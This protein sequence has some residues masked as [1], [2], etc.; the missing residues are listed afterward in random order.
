M[1]AGALAA[2]LALP[3]AAAVGRDLKLCVEKLKILVFLGGF[4]KRTAPCRGEDL[5]WAEKIWKA[6]SIFFLFLSF[7]LSL[8]S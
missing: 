5:I 3:S 4:Y 1:L 2:A 8:N 6:Y 7:F